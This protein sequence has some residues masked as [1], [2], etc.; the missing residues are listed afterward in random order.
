MKI[1]VIS[2][3]SCPYA[4]LGGETAGG[5]SVYL[6]ELLSVLSGYKNTDIDVFTRTMDPQYRNVKEIQDS[7]R[8]VHIDAGPIQPLDRTKL[9]S[10]VP[11]FI[12][13]LE[14]YIIREKREYDIIYSHYWLS[15][16]IGEWIR[17][18]YSVPM[19]HT[20]HSLQFFKERAV[21]GDGDEIRRMAEEHL[22]E[23]CETIIS[24]SDQEQR[25][26]VELMGVDP[27]KCRVIYPGIN[28]ALFHPG[29]KFLVNEEIR[30][31]EDDL[32]ML[33]VG[34]IEPVK[35]LG[36]IIDGLDVLRV[37][38]PD[39][40]KRFKLIVIGGGRLDGEFK[41]NKEIALIRKRLNEQDMPD[42]ILFL[43][44]KE[45]EELYKYYSAADA[46]L[47]PS[48]YESFGLVVGESLSC[49]TPVLV[50][51]VG[52][53]GAFVQEGKNGFTF[54]AENPSSFADVMTR[55]AD[56]RDS[57]WNKKRIRKHIIHRLDWEKSAA[58]IYKEFEKLKGVKPKP[59]TISLHD[60]N[61]QPM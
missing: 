5:M 28:A 45:Q 48:L 8:V 55:F 30:R 24:S 19:V 3:H 21:G 6:K 43:G 4:F 17:T 31:R 34:R 11:E 59:T 42:K 10:H 23:V 12:R 37:E 26:L 13:N 57:L 7:L 35:G 2:Y 49:G 58:A 53:M 22:P 18:N 61:L 25:Y 38:Q 50:S 52:E 20:F 36:R 32:L 44:S 47:L 51:N 33:Y 1:C 16:L 41:T 46:L 56:Q 14:S 9:F 60:E 39:L 54:A 29:D 15:G 40:F 27:S